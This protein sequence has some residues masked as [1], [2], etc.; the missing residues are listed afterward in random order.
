VA[1]RIFDARGR[2]VRELKPGL[3]H[4]GQQRVEWDGRD[5]AGSLCGSGTYHIRMDVGTRNFTVK[6]VLLK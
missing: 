4:A 3:C 5:A 1:F 2:L 6:A